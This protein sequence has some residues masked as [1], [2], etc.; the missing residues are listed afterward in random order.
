MTVA[1]ATAVLPVMP[2]IRDHAPAADADALERLA[3]WAVRFTPRVATDPA[4]D[5]LILDVAGCERLYGGLVPLARGVR[6]A[7]AE[8]GLGVRV[9][10][11]PTVSLAWGKARFGTE[12]VIA[13]ADEL[14]ALP[15]AALRVK[16]DVVAALA[17]VGVD[18]VGELEALP[19]KEI[20]RRFGHGV[21]L[22]ID[23]ARGEAAEPID[24]LPHRT[25]PAARLRFAGPTTQFEAIARAAE[26]LAVELCDRLAQIESAARRVVWQIERLNADLRPEFAAESIALAAPTRD[27]KHLWHVLRPKV[28]AMHLGRGVEAMSLSAVE[29]CRQPHAQSS[30]GGER[31]PTIDD[32]DVAQLID[33]LQSK[34]GRGNV[35]R[36][37][38][39][40]THVPEA[41]HR[42]VPAD[43]PRRRIKAWPLA[44][45]DRPTRLLDPP[46]PADVVF[47]H[48][49]GPLATL[50]W[51]G[52]SRAILTTVGPERVGRRWWRF[53]LGRRTLAVRDYYK[54]QCEGGLWLWVFRARPA[55]EWRVHGVWA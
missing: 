49:E 25:T 29:A 4:G 2:L 44:E 24:W 15:V 27:A 14:I 39:T 8:L 45:A 37:E 33:R 9:A 19:R 5:G 35:C 7:T 34:L 48:P 36:I 16:A 22:R 26:H 46:E 31:D 18:R 32:R 6:R 40:P 12:G 30:L 38:P 51:R 47:L 28:E 54:L 11:A 55:D 13:N 21:L 43:E 17:E 42:L 1:H 52:V 20:A 3:R 23:Q 41:A 53:G 10:V 50:R